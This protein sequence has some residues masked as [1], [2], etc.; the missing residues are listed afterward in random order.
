MIENLFKDL[1]SWEE[2]YRRERTP[3]PL[4]QQQFDEDA[5][6]VDELQVSPEQL[7]T[8]EQREADK[9]GWEKFSALQDRYS[10]CCRRP[11]SS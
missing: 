1:T 5:D 3:E 6:P 2:R 10:G 11:K 7:E 9:K 8:E 4:T